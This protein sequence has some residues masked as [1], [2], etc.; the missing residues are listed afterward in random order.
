M[1]KRFNMWLEEDQDKKIG[2]FADAIPGLSKS[3]V[4]RM[5]IDDASI[6]QVFRI[7]AEKITDRGVMLGTKIDKNG[8]TE[9]SSEVYS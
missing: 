1:D 8:S 7:F 2:G 9:K 3:A 6:D 4:V 5:L